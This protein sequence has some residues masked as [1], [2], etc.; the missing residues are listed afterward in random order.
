MPLPRHG[1]YGEE[2]YDR[3]NTRDCACSDAV[4][5]DPVEHSIRPK[6]RQGDFISSM[7]HGIL[8]RMHQRRG[9][10]T[11]LAQHID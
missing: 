1:T 8:L 7:C 4:Q 2:Q 10:R 3:Q 6:S 11:L 5:N 9:S